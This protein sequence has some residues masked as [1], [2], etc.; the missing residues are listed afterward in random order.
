MRHFLFALSQLT[1]A[2]GVGCVIAGAALPISDRRVGE[3]LTIGLLIR[4]AAVLTLS[5]AAKFPEA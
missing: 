3:L 2:A 5:A 4:H 1:L